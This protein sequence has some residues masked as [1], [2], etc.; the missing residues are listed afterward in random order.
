MATLAEI[1]SA[2]D[3][4]GT[5]TQSQ[6]TAINADSFSLASA[7]V[8]EEHWGL[9]DYWLER[10]TLFPAKLE[11]FATKYYTENISDKVHLPEYDYVQFAVE[12]FQA[13]R[14]TATYGMADPRVKRYFRFFIGL[15]TK[16]G[17][18]VPG[19][20]LGEFVM[21]LEEHLVEGS[22]T[23]FDESASDKLLDNYLTGGNPARTYGHIKSKKAIY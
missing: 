9:M 14:A 11:E 17:T 23:F 2:F 12:A 13:A 6:W 19:S 15:A 20:G 10:M 18:G 22:G 7:A 4:A 16:L 3:G 8:N 5:L 1:V 21:I